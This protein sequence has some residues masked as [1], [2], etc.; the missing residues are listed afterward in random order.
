MVIGRS[1][2]YGDRP[3]ARV[4]E[5]AEAYEIIKSLLNEHAFAIARAEAWVKRY[6]ENKRERKEM[7]DPGPHPDEW[8]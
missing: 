4:D 7:R 3:P 5:R 1:S 6:E 8:S 2:D